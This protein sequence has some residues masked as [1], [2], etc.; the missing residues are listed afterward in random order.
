MKL[1][2]TLEDGTT[3][4]VHF[5]PAVLDGLKSL[6]ELVVNDTGHKLTSHELAAYMPDVDVCVTHWGAPRFDEEVLAAADKLKVIAHAA[7]SVATIATDAAYR[8]GIHV[9]SA[10]NIMATRVAEAALG[11]MIAG[12]RFFHEYWADIR[13]GGWDAARY[14][15]FSLYGAH[16]SL[17]GL[18]TIG[19]ILLEHLKPFSSMVRI[20]DPYITPESLSALPFAS[21]CSLDE[22][23]AFGDIVSLHASLTK[24]TY[25]MLTREKLALIREGSLLINTARGAVIDED[26]LIEALAAGRIRALL[27][28]FETEPP[29]PDSPLRHMPNVVLQPHTAGATAGADM[30]VGIIEDLRRWQ[31]GEPFTLEVSHT[32]F[33][34]MTDESIWR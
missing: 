27:D 2:L 19:R 25:H 9:L 4:D 28:V 3:K 20:Y 6:G 8:R 17:I 22:A 26:A 10:N 13:A 23:L 21:L 29:P 18:G 7:G 30:T 1:F 11:H 14:P 5:P 24:E 33:S 12:G 31:R 16:I 34:R 15:M 32:Q